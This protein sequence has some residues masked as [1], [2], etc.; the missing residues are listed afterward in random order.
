[1]KASD[2]MNRN[3]VTIGPGASLEEAARVMGNLLPSCDVLFASEA[4][5]EH[6]F[7]IQGPDFVSVATAISERFGVKIVVGTRREATLV[8]RNR[9]AAIGWAADQVH[10]SPWYDVEIVDR[11]GAGDAM[12]S[13]VIHGLLDGDLKKAIDYGAAFGAIKHTIPGDLAWVTAEEIEAVLAG[14]GLRVRR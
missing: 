2:V 11:L 5:A 12:A 7:G 1:M 4:D 13:G 8:W 3:V 10:E 6:L 14:Q 9:F